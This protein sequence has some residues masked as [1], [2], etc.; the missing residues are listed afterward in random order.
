VIDAARY[1]GPRDELPPA[2]YRLAYNPENDRHAHTFCMC[3]GGMVVPASAQPGHV[4]VN[5]M[6][7]AARRAFWANSAVI[8]EVR[9][10]DYGGEGPLAGYAFQDR[11]ERACFAFTGDTERAPAQRVSD[12]LAGRASTDLPRVSYPLG[13][14][15]CDLREV[16][17]DFIVEG[18]KKAI[19][20]F[21]KEVPGF[22]GEG[23]VLIA[24]ET[25]TTSPVRF[26]RKESGESTTLPGLFPIG[27]GAG[28]GGGIVSCALDGLRVGRALATQGALLA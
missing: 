1:G 6:S 13:V 8:V 23:G 11:I 19:L 26:L 22:A 14:V 10:E 17:P 15:P 27:E 25:R 16:L 12:L 28:H 3:P 2:S 24:P 4:V 5:G 18:M 21:D 20:S 7:F 9:P